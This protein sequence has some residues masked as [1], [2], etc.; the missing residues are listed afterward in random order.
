M[1]DSDAIACGLEELEGDCIAEALIHPC[2]YLRTKSDQH[3]NEF[4]ITQDKALEDKIKRLEFEITN[5]KKM[6]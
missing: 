3:Y 4:L 6:F 1:M 2:N 5:Y